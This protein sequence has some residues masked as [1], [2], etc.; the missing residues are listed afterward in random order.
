MLA[1]MMGLVFEQ[2]IELSQSSRRLVHILHRCLSLE[3]CP[4]QVHPNGT[5]TF[6]SQTTSTVGA[7]VV[8]S[9][10]IGTPAT[11]VA[12]GALAQ[13]H[14]ASVW[15][16]LWC[17]SRQLWQHSGFTLSLVSKELECCSHS[18]QGHPPQSSLRTPQSTS[19]PLQGR[20][21]APGARWHATALLALPPATHIWRLM[22]SHPLLCTL[23]TAFLL[24]PVGWLQQGGGRGLMGCS[25]G[26]EVQ[27]PPH[28]L[29]FHPL[30]LVWYDAAHPCS[31]PCLP[32]CLPACLQ[33][34][35]WLR[36][37]RGGGA[38][39]LLQRL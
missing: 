17:L 23:P 19:P 31:A 25:R 7:L 10:Y 16:Q 24:L 28:F 37:A 30:H 36:A 35:P 3:W 18:A 29:L 5:W 39:G 2:L 6:S 34:V 38:D 1:Q 21:A 26:A 4:S 33:K 9:L 15:C 8:A 11:T 14:Q 20:P 22:Q 12:S 13:A 27:K 32:A